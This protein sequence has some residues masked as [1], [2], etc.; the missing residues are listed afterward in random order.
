MGE[1]LLRQARSIFNNFAEEQ[2]RPYIAKITSSAKKNVTSKVFNDPIWNS[3]TLRPIEI[4]VLDSPLMQRLR[5]IRQLG[6]A[7]WV[8]PGAEHS[9][10]QHSIGTVH[11][12][13]QLISSINAS[14][15]C[16][17]RQQ[18]KVLRMAALCHDIGQ[19]V[20]SHVSENAL[21]EE[22]KSFKLDF[23]DFLNF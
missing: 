9:R 17:N 11:Q 10:F 16:I 18:E 20:M 19:G 4:L 23:A 5:N 3:I 13:S 21:E 12:I 14:L 1:E 15:P 22:T 2:L 8:Y 7:H 6:V